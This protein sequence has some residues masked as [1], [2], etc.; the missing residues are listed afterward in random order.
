MSIRQWQWWLWQC[1]LGNVHHPNMM[2][3]P[4]VSRAIQ[5]PLVVFYLLSSCSGTL[6]SV[7]WRCIPE[8]ICLKGKDR[9]IMITYMAAYSKNNS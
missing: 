4:M 6:R 8:K 3:S 9:Q 2:W 5:G 1:R 7:R